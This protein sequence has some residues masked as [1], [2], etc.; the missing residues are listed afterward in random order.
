MLRDVFEI[1]FMLTK[2]KRGKIQKGIPSPGSMA[3]LFRLFV[4]FPTGPKAR[5]SLIFPRSSV[6]YV[7]YERKLGVLTGVS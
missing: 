5:F 2:L 3:C 7:H 4:C 1:G 6:E